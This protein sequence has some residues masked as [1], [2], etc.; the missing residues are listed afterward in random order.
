VMC[1]YKDRALVTK[2]YCPLCWELEEIWGEQAVGYKER[3][4]RNK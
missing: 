1:P 4:E 2:N 3:R